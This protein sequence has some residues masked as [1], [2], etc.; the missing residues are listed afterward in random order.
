MNYSNAWLIQQIITGETP[1][2]TCFLSDRCMQNADWDTNCFNENYY[3]PFKVEGIVYNTVQHWL[4]AQKAALFYDA[5]SMEKIIACKTAAHAKLLGSQIKQVDE[6]VWLANA[7]A[8]V[9]KGN[10]HKFAQHGTL[11]QK[12]I[13]TSHS[14]IVAITPNDCLWGNGMNY[15]PNQPFNPIK[16]KGANLLGYA[17]MDVRDI[18]LAEKEMV[19]HFN[20]NIVSQFLSIAQ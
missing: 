11:K 2:Y 4:M 18:L 7:Y 15:Q 1:S 10:V 16:W 13:N 19:H 20:N 6:D 14:I 3:A 5:V 9:V 12:L 8:L 17:L